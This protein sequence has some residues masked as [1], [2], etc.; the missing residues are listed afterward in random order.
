MYS[1][2][3]AVPNNLMPSRKPKC[4]G[5]GSTQKSWKE[6]HRA[7]SGSQTR[8]AHATQDTHAAFY[9][10]FHLPPCLQLFFPPRL[11]IQFR[12][13]LVKHWSVKLNVTTS[14]S[15][16]WETGGKKLM[17]LSFKNSGNYFSFPVLPS[18]YYFISKHLKSYTRVTFSEVS[19]LSDPHLCF[20]VIYNATK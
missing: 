6:R 2:D 11:C 18:S 12:S 13:D 15:T 5:S 14:Q 17:W 3:T 9:S 20:P 10:M 7:G 16:P 8:L 4:L 1:A 19:E